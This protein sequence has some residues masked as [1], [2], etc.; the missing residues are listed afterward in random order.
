MKRF[1]ALLVTICLTFIVFSA[2]GNNEIPKSKETTY[3]ALDYFTIFSSDGLIID[4]IVINNDLSGYFRFTT[5]NAGES[6]KKLRSDNNT[7]G[8]LERINDSAFG[9][10]NKEEYKLV[11]VKDDAIKTIDEQSYIDISFVNINHFKGNIKVI[12]LATY[13]DDQ[14]VEEDNHFTDLKGNISSIKNISETDNKQI[15]IINNYPK[16]NIEITF[17]G[18]R[19][20]CYKGNNAVLE[21]NTISFENNSATSD[22]SYKVVIEAYEF[23]TLIIVFS[24]VFLLGLVSIILIR[25]RVFSKNK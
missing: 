25:F 18:N 23:P 1:F 20:V 3:S 12:D 15:A 6:L 8:R 21:K 10:D 24:V 16:P 7:K 9:S 13:L 22:N 14:F 11:Y 2:C 19:I 17:D 4:S 5:K